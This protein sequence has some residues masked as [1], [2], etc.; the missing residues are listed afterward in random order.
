MRHSWIL[1]LFAGLVLFSTPNAFGQS[2]GDAAEKADNLRL[3]L[4]DVQTREADLQER[5]RQLDED[6][7]PENI[8]RS[9]AG[10]GSTRPE[11][12]REYR[13]R[14][15]QIERDKVAAQLALLAKN[16][17]DLESA[18]VAADAEAYHQSARA[19][20]PTTLDQAVLV[21]VSVLPLWVTLLIAL[22]LLGMVTA[23]LIFVVKRLQ[24]SRGMQSG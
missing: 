18:I 23:A 11:E 19:I 3:Q 4:I 16:R 5:L 17:T 10:I 9:L 1:V 2:G 22:V 14:Q 21:Q 24:R 20:S 8:E 13:R 6:L 7:K 15:L 12:L